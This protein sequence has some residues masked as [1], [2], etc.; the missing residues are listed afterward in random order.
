MDRSSGTSL[1]MEFIWAILM[2]RPNTFVHVVCVLSL[3]QHHIGDLRRFCF[4]LDLPNQN[5]WKGF[6]WFSLNSFRALDICPLNCGI[7]FRNNWHPSNVR[8]YSMGCR[9]CWPMYCVH[10][11]WCNAVI[12]KVK[13]K[14][15][16]VI[17]AINTY[18]VRGNGLELDV[19]EY[20]RT[21]RMHLYKWTIN[22]NSELELFPMLHQ[23][24][25]AKQQY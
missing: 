21:Q 7:N 23:Q 18:T 10:Q 16:F 15:N 22:I 6:S 20:K 25:G 24:S 17:S 1:I 8:I 2:L 12:I 5:R 13:V 3:V 14:G 19:T 9:L 11:F 4:R